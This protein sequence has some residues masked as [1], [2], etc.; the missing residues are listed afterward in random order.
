MPSWASVS[1]V[2]KR[3]IDVIIL[4]RRGRVPSARRYRASRRF[5]NA[6]FGAGAA[7]RIG[8]GLTPGGGGGTRD[9]PPCT[10]DGFGVADAADA[11]AEEEEEEEEAATPPRSAATSRSVSGENESMRDGEMADCGN[12]VARARRVGWGA[13]G[14]S[15][16]PTAEI[17]R[18][19][20]GGDYQARTI[21]APT[22]PQVGN[23]A[24]GHSRLGPSHRHMLGMHRALQP[25]PDSTQHRRYEANFN[26]PWSIYLVVAHPQCR[27]HVP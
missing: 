22:A 6:S 10:C 13:A 26:S 3:H 2:A 16:R 1:P 25:V 15:Y 18:E 8:A 27:R 9:G 14:E 20:I 23:G 17:N 11:E 24:S 12:V 7:L 5:G 4:V 19:I 21:P